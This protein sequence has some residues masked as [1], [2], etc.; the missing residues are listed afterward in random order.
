MNTS[1]VPDLRGINSS[2]VS[3]L[4]RSQVSNTVLALARKAGDETGQAALRPAMVDGSA[5]LH[6]IAG[7]WAARLIADTAGY[8]ARR[9]LTQARS[10][11]TSW[12]A[13]GEALLYDREHV[14]PAEMAFRRAA[15]HF[16]PADS[17]DRAYWDCKGADGCG[18]WITDHGPYTGHPVD[19]E[20]GHA[21]G[22]ARH[23]RE[24]TA[25]EAGL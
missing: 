1:A 13:I 21:D 10:Q 5:E 14:D 3:Y 11:G 23:A 20:S 18:Q 16:G 25:W 8:Q 7:Y 15:E 24:V 17:T 6:P 12:R 9:C 22:C 2:E 19:C 4:A